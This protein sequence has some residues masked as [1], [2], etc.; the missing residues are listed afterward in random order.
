[1]PL[2]VPSTARRRLIAAAAAAILASLGLLGL[3]ASAQAR[4]QVA[5][6]D[7]SVFLY[8]RYYNVD[9]AYKQAAEIGARWL[10]LNV[11]WGDFKRYGFGPIDRAVNEARAHGFSV[12]FTVAGTPQYDPRGDRY[13]R[14]YKPNAS[15]YASFLKRV[16]R[17]YRGKVRRYS[18]WNE[19]NL[20]RWI[21]PTR[22]APRYYRNL[23]LKGYAA[24]KSVDRRNQV[25]IGE[26]TSAHNPLSFLRNL[27]AAGRIRAD[28]LAY[29]PFQFGVE[30]GR[31][32]RTSFVGISDTRL[33]QSTLR[34]LRGRFGRTLPI[35]FTEFGYQ[36]PGGGVY[37]QSESSRTAWTVKAFQLVQRYGVKEMLYYQLI[38]SP[39]GTLRGDI[40]DSGIVNLNGTPTSVF[41][42]MVKARRSYA[43]F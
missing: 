41:A 7:D 26:L 39:P 36:G 15:R 34:S 31:R 17:R 19:P 35:Y 20:P 13:I 18:I 1:M 30:P 32:N 23:V 4:M 10:R 6:Q 5:V 38:H 22:Q 12:Q 8:H 28:G 42:A 14:Y 3:A 11:I 33:I 2:V 40:W 25:L 37:H 24:L 21:S 43:G 9:T 29:H 16:A 27:G